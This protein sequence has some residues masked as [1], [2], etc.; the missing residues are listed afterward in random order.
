MPDAHHD[1]QPAAL[2]AALVPDPIDQAARTVSAVQG[3]DGLL[4]PVRVLYEADARSAV[5]QAVRTAT[6]SVLADAER[7]AAKLIEA[8]RE[9]EEA[10]AALQ[11]WGFFD[12]DLDGLAE[13][14][15][16]EPCEY[17]SPLQLIEAM[18]K[19]AARQPATAV[20]VLAKRRQI[21]ARGENSGTTDG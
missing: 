7:T 9:L 6:E 17:P 20:E 5:D 21:I 15:G 10:N 18:L 8:R 1:P 12:L 19:E 13:A 3:P 11:A 14:L 2:P 16:V 4:A